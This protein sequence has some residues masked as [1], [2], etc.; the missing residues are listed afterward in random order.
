VSQQTQWREPS[1]FAAGDTLSFSRRL[2]DYPASQGWSL[3]YELRGGSQAIEFVSAADGDAHVMVV[4]KDTT[5]AWLPGD[6]VMAGFAVNAGQGLRQQI[7]YGDLLV[8]A[9]LPV[10]AG[11]EPQLT[12]A[13]E[14]IAKYEL[15][16]KAKAGDDLARSAVGDTGFWF[17][18]PAQL[19][20]EW[21]YWKTVR[22]QEVAAERA[23]AGKPTGNKV[24]SVLRVLNGG[25]AFG[26][27][28]FGIGG[29]PP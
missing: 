3:L 24:R 11:N 18:T 4:S 20:E 6:Y 9:N 5:A 15:V 14:M 25:P 28:G 27:G 8:G 12:L 29:N 21:G 13:Q 23:K 17:L 16:M 19:R 22:R 7:Y 1:E 26:A 2:A 10:T